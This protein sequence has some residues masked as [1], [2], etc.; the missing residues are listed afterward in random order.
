M[1]MGVAHKLPEQSTHAHGGFLVS[2]RLPSCCKHR[3]I[4][5]KGTGSMSNT[6]AAQCLQELTSGQLGFGG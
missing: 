4:Q 6:R 1:G 3:K 5:I 2:R